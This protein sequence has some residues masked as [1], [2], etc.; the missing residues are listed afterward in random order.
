MKL[1]KYEKMI[2]KIFSESDKTGHVHC[3]ECPLN[4]DKRDFICYFNI[5]GRTEEARE[6]NLKRY[7]QTDLLNIFRCANERK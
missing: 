7:S 4:I 1:N 6:L 2:C 5:D 3:Y